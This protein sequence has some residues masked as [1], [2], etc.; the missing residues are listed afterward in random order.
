MKEEG[1]DR[2]EIF[3]AKCTLSSFVCDRLKH[4]SELYD[5]ISSSPC[6][7]YVS[8]WNNEENLKEN[9]VQN[10]TRQAVFSLRQVPTAYVMGF[11]K[12]EQGIFQSEL[13]NQ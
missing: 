1:I 7:S 2:C 5:M 9:Q 4:M 6:A 3:T 13:R 8:L 12:T 10:P 11:M